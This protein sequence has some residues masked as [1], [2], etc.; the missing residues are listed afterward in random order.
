MDDGLTLEVRNVRDAI[1]PASQQAEDWL[2]NFNPSLDALYLVRLAIEE[3]VLNC[4]KYGY[5]D[6]AEHTIVIKLIVND[7]ALTMTVIDDGHPFDPLAAPPPDLSVDIHDR[8]KGGLGIYLLREL[9]DNLAYR[10]FDHT[11]QLTLMKRMH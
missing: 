2:T 1:A 10:R 6:A 4:I 9:A 7:Q 5:D 11:N 8:R 3:L